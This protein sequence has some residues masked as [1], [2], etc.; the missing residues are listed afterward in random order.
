MPIPREVLLALHAVLVAVQVLLQALINW[1]DNLLRQEVTPA[2]RPV[3]LPGNYADEESF[4]TST[5]TIERQNTPP[6]TILDIQS[7]NEEPTTPPPRQFLYRPEDCPNDWHLVSPGN[8]R[9]G[10]CNGC[11]SPAAT[12]PQRTG[13]K[14]RLRYIV[15]R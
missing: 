4:E 15:Q 2:A 3:A 11:G 1:V 8:R 13:E 9:I 14:H 10:T 12:T 7:L 6:T 5:A